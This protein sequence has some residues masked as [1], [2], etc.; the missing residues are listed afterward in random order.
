[1]MTDK[2]QFESPEEIREHLRSELSRTDGSAVE[3]MHY[4][5]EL[6]HSL[7]TESTENDFDDVVG[8]LVTEWCNDNPDVAQGLTHAV[9]HLSGVVNEAA[10]Q[11]GFILGQVTT[12]LEEW[13]RNNP[14]VVEKIVATFEIFTADGQAAQ[15]R[16]RYDKDGVTI[17]FERAVRLA[18]CLMALRI[19]YDGDRCPDEGGLTQVYDFEMRAIYALRDG[20]L[21]ELLEGAQTSPLDFRALRATLT[22]LR[23][24]HEPIPSELN[25]WALQLAAGEVNVPRPSTGRSPYKNVVRDEL[26]TKTVQSLVGCGLSA[27][28]NEASYPKKSAC[29]AVS[30]ALNA[31]GV[32]L[33]YT[34]VAKV[35]QFRKDQEGK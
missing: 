34:G 31:H 8:P 16:D 11:M 2:A 7:R 1:M 10:R 13:V 23:E 4:I 15:W 18:F 5:H 6:L 19:P 32:P 29:H 9:T 33:G 28:R 3:R 35:W 24:G 30:K 20:R 22:Y 17:P 26:I 21:E 25:E 12:A 27:T 14:E